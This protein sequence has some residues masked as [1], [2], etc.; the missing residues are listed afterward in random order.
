MVHSSLILPL[1][2]TLAAAYARAD[3]IANAPSSS[4]SSLTFER[5]G[6]KAS[7][8][9]VN[10]TSN[11]D[12]STSSTPL[13]SWRIAG[14]DA[15]SVTLNYNSSDIIAGYG[16]ADLALS[17]SLAIN[18][19][20]DGASSAL[21]SQNVSVPFVQI[22]KVINQYCA[23]A[24]NFTAVVHLSNSTVIRKTAINNLSLDIPDN[25]S[26]VKVTAIDTGGIR[27]DVETLAYYSVSPVT[28]QYGSGSN[29]PTV[30]GT[31]TVEMD[32][33]TEDD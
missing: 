13:V 32:Y 31:Y 11:V 16:G 29:V 22:L 7:W 24:Q 2:F 21:A 3:A 27:T 6:A 15:S 23:N 4:N 33:C 10:D 26:S 8:T 20:Y 5:A 25:A 9:A 18:T 12:L 28:A 19:T 14:D 30:T 17:V 1:A